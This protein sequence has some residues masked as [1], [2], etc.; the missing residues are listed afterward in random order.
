MD[1]GIEGAYPLDMKGKEHILSNVEYQQVPKWVLKY[2]PEN[3]DWEEKYQKYMQDHKSTGRSRRGSQPKEL[4]YIPRL[5]LQLQNEKESAFKRIVDGPSFKA[6][7]YNRYAVNGSSPKDRN[8]V[9]DEASYFGVVQKILELD[10]EDF[11][12]T[13][14]YYDRRSTSEDDE[15]F[16]LDSQI[17]QVF[18]CKDLSRDNWH[19][20]L[21]APMML[22]QEV[23][24]YEDPLVFEART[25]E[26]SSSI[27]LLED[28]LVNDD[29]EWI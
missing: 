14:F 26:D 5:R 4:D 21:D 27:N 17:K 22:S 15:P 20:V 13:V 6:M 12:Q 11:K 1:D 3:V 28:I 7:S 10:Y 23:D 9:D 19:V 29:E 16:I 25:K 24:A 18:Y 8:L 2:S